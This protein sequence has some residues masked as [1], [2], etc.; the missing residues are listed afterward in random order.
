VGRG[1]LRLERGPGRGSSL[2]D[3]CVLIFQNEDGNAFE[4]RSKIKD[5]SGY[6][7]HIRL[8]DCLHERTS[9]HYADRYQDV[10]CRSSR[11]GNLLEL[12]CLRM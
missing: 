10:V 12:L 7:H 5:R 11:T 9:G 6:L 2:F 1:G 8:I 3:G 4:W